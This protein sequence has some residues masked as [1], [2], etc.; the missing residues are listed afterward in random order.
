MIKITEKALEQLKLM[1]KEKNQL[2]R[3]ILKG[4]GCAGFSYKFEFTDSKEDYEKTIDDVLVVDELSLQMLNNCVVDYF[5][6]GFE[7]YFFL[8]I[9]NVKSKCGCGKSFSL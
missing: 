7:K 4:S 2:V 9:P 8:H 1:K 6:N 3:L 5:D